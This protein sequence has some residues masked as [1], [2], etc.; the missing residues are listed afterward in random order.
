[1][2]IEPS[3]YAV[4]ADLTLAVHAAFVAFVVGGQVAILIGWLT[5]WEWTRG[6][7]FR[8]THLAAIGFVVLESWFEIPCSLTVLENALRIRSGT[9]AYQQGFLG[10]WLAR[11]LFYSAPP[12]VFTLIHT[13]FGALVL[14]TFFA[15]PPK[16][17]R[18]G[19]AT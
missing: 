6:R 3:D 8:F 18:T 4:L 12:W 14:T 17:S 13:L 15:Y 16:R 11:L 9:A 1:M 7:F 2:T 5:G 19:V 10:Y